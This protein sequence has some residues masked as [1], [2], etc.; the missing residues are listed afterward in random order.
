M[1]EINVGDKIPLSQEGWKK[2]SVLYG[3]GIQ[4]IFSGTTQDSRIIIIL[5]SNGFSRYLHFSL[6]NTFPVTLCLGKIA[7]IE[8]QSVLNDGNT[9]VIKTLPE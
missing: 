5:E 6:G 7:T 8:I 2:L 3:P 4:L 1:K 9:I